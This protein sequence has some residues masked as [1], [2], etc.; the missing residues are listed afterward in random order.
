MA[1]LMKERVC[2][3]EVPDKRDM[4]QKVGHTRSDIGSNYVVHNELDPCWFTLP[5]WMVEA[6][7]ALQNIFLPFDSMG[8]SFSDSGGVR[9]DDGLQARQVVL[10]Q[11]DRS[12][13]IVD[14]A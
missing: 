5:F 4:P 11:F 7:A 8:L 10:W 12:S 13:A 3:R 9:Q 1:H 14:R 2:K 6:K